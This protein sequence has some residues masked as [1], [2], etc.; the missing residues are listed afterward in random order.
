MLNPVDRE[1]DDRD[2]PFRGLIAIAVVAIIC[3]ALGFVIVTSNGNRS[4]NE[5]RG[6]VT[7]VA[8]PYAR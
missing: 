2:L 8:H 5:Y 3:L 1:G 7:P 4:V 6:Y